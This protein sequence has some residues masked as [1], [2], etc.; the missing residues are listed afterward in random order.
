MWPGPS[1][2]Q[3]LIAV[4]LRTTSQ[5]S[6]VHKVNE[7]ECR[8]WTICHRRVHMWP[9]ALTPDRYKCLITDSRRAGAHRAKKRTHATFD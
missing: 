3:M 7:G 5:V 2:C 4:N 6:R 1:D 9:P 8:T